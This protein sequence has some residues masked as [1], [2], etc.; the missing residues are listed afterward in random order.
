V[1]NGAPYNHTIQI[2]VDHSGWGD[3]RLYHRSNITDERGEQQ[4]AKTATGID[5]RACLRGVSG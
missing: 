4:S 1:G 3:E 2:D 5:H